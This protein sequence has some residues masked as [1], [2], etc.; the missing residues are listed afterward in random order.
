MF[1]NEFFSLNQ[2][3]VDEIYQMKPQFGYNGYGEFV[4]YR[5]YSRLKEG[6]LNE[7]WHDVVIRVIEGV[8]SIRLDWYTKNN[9]YWDDTRWQAFARSMAISM[10]K[11]EWL[12]P[13]RGLWAMGT[14]FVYQ[15]G[16]MALNNC[17]FTKIGTSK[18]H[19]DF[20][21]LMDALMLGVG[22][23]FEPVNEQFDIFP[24]KKADFLYIIPDSREGWVN[25]VQLLVQS[26]IDPNAKRP[27]FD[28]SKIRPRGELIHGFGG[29][30][31]G[32][33]PL[34]ELHEEITQIF[35][36]G[37]RS[38][39]RL[40]TDIANLIGVCVV[41]GNVRRSAEIAIGDIENQEFLDLK[42]YQLHPERAAYG[43]MSNNTAKFKKRSDFEL[44]GELTRRVVVRGEPGGMNMKNIPFGRIGRALDVPLDAAEGLNPCG[45]IP[46][47]DKELCNLA[48][49]LPT[50][51]SYLDDWYGAC[52]FATFYAS[53]TSLLLT[54]RQE[55]NAV[56]G[57]NRRIGVDIIDF[58][59]WKHN[60]GL[61][62][63]ID[64]MEQGY[65]IVRKTNKVLN[66]EA[67]VPP[68]I[69]VTTVKPGG[70]IPKLAGKTAGIGHPTFNHTLRRTR[71]ASDSPVAKLLIEANVPHHPDQYDPKTLIFEFPIL[72]GPARPA[73]QVSLW[74]QAANLMVLQAHWADN[75]VSNTLYF[76][77]KWCLF[78]SVPKG[79]PFD[80]WLED[81]TKLDYNEIVQLE[82]MLV[83]KIKESNGWK[84]DADGHTIN[85]YQF[86]PNH[87]EDEIEFVIS[88]FISKFKS[89]SLLPHSPKG[90]YV[91]M[92]EEGITEEEY[93]ELLSKISPID[94][95][96]LSG[97]D[98]E[99]EKFCQGD[100]C[101]LNLGR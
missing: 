73:D 80:E 59:G 78:K 84:V 16:S 81:N 97:S 41:A 15:H 50:M 55:T 87:E 26:F 12:P 91:D 2:E 28:Y 14:P 63:C 31:S 76:K 4:F 13:G 30:A 51:C 34:K 17:G 10:F 39:V 66:A 25:S 37:K 24:H 23:G 82:R 68:A 95:S 62:N 99:D 38:P 3:T 22:V 96:R 29:I 18:M 101:E 5:T 7:T 40:K 58:T 43:R 45:E 67:G 75:A 44:I 46:L 74:E 36:H 77:P 47:E 33:D 98:G 69:R 57:R 8:M 61:H 72:Q 93:E 100:V 65:N 19:L 52:R 42:D 71:V 48:C 56:I 9:I 54:H 85:V 21:W 60:I 53:T 79:E 64:A 27:R 92:P 70:T 20:G 6:G 32:P 83:N 90:A 35:L 1:V 94:W 88:S 49:T 86:D 89:F 11:M